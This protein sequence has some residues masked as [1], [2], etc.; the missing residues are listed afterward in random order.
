[1]IERGLL[2]V[3]I[4]IL[5]LLAYC[6]YTRWQIWRAARL[7][8]RDPL[9]ATLRPGVPAILYFTTPTCAPC[10]HRQRPALRRLLDELGDRVQLIEV[11]AVEQ[12]DAA[13]RWGVL[14]VP[15]TFILDG[16]GRPQQ[17]NHGVT[18]TEKLR[19]QVQ[20]LGA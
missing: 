3:G 6:A 2:L 11:N 18:G 16:Q 10:I 4:A 5:G 14:S 19:R 1:M 15:T 13:D 9:L 20:S 12:P 17:V 8:P 7:A